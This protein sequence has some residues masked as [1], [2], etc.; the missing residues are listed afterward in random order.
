MYNIFLMNDNT[1]GR[2]M[3]LDS[4]RDCDHIRLALKQ[5][6]SL[7]QGFMREKLGYSHSHLTE[8]VNRLMCE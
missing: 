4:L 2:R 7:V 5:E 6:K 8:G 3:S 1:L